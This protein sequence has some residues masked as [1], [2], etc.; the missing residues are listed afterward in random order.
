MSGVGQCLNLLGHTEEAVSMHK[1]QLERAEKEGSVQER[2]NA[3]MDLSASQ[4]LLD[5]HQSL[6][7]AVALAEDRA[8]GDNQEIDEWV[9]SNAY[10]R[11]GVM[12]SNRT[13]CRRVCSKCILHRRLLVACTTCMGNA[14][15]I[16]TLNCSSL[17]SGSDA[18]CG[19]SKEED[20]MRRCCE[21]QQN[22]KP[23]TTGL[24]PRDIC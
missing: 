2:I 14:I 15:A 23:R 19:K 21:E 24:R 6:G 20:M 5:A 11:F 4:P 8:G 9:L 13:F 17:F 16:M 10:F 3:L 18:E 7:R 12:S 22:T 1:K